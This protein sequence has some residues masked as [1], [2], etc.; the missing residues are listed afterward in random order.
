MGLPE[1]EASVPTITSVT[2]PFASS[3]INSKSSPEAKVKLF[4][5]LFRGREDVYAVR[6]EG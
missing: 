2:A 1:N 3:T 6:W 4:R 5:S